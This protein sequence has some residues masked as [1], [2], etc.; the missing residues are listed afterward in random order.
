MLRLARWR[1]P[2]AAVGNTSVSYAVTL[3]LKNL[4]NGAKLLAVHA[5]AQTT[6]RT[7]GRARTGL[8]WQP[9]KQHLGTAFEARR[10]EPS[11][12]R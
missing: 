9:A 10:L 4:R 11:S 1:V 7:S 5:A 6:Q 2:F 3:A 8:G 12:N